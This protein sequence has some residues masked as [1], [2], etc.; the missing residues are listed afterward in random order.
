MSQAPLWISL[1]GWILLSIADLYQLNKI[2]RTFSSED[3]HALLIRT[4]KMDYHLINLCKRWW[5]DWFLKQK[6]Y[7]SD[8]C[9]KHINQVAD[10]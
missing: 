9:A 7:G 5:F 4:L 2:Y 3:Y 8:G 6:R 10:Q 1:Q